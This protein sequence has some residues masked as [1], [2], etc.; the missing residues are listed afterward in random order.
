MDKS[1]VKLFNSPSISNSE[2]TWEKSMRKARLVRANVE[3]LQWLKNGNNTSP[4]LREAY[5]AKIEWT[6][7]LSP[8][9][10]KEAEAR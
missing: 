2:T 7:K 4:Q 6:R 8:K 1:A 10:K 3:W 9:L 5:S